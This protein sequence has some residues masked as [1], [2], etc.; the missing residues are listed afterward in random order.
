MNQFFDKRYHPTNYNCGHFVSELWQYLTGENI[1][2][3]IT[4]FN[5]QSIDCY[6]PYHSRFNRIRSPIPNCLVLMRDNTLVPHVGVF[7]DSRVL[8]LTPNGV[9]YQT[10]QELEKEHTLSYFK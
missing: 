4:A 10:V 5:S 8:H 3:I 6:R 2:E 1:D 7:Y 9:R